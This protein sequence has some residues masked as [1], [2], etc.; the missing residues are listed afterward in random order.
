MSVNITITTLGRAA[1]VNAENTGTNPVVITQVG[2]T[3]TAVT[4]TVGTTSL[5]GELKRISGVAGDVVADDTI[6]INLTDDSGDAYSMRSFALYLADGTLFAIYGQAAP[7][8][9][10]TAE[11]IAAIAIDTIF[12]DIDAALL[13]FGTAEFT[14]PPATTDRAGVVELATVA[15]A[16]AG[17]DAL[18]ALTPATAKAAI[19]GWLLSQDGSGSGLDA[20]LL[21]GQDGSYY[22]NIAARLG[23]TPVN[24]A[25]DLMTGLL[26]LSGAPT[27]TD[28]ATT[29]AYVDALVTASAL[30]TKL[31]TVDGSGSGLDSDLLDGQD[32]AYYANIAARLG[33][34]PVNKA[35]D[36]M[37]G[38]LRRSGAPP[39]TDH[40]TTKAY[41]DAL[42][43]AAAIKTALLTV[44][45]S[46]SGIDADLLDGLDAAVFAR[47]AG[48]TLTGFLSLHADPTAAMHAATRQWVL[49]QIATGAIGFTPVNRAGDTMTGLLRLSAAPTLADHA[50]TK[51]YVDALVTAAAIKTALLTVDGSGSGIDADLLDGQDGAYYADIASRLGFSPVNKAGDTMLGL[52]TLSGAPT[53]ANHAATKIYVD[54]LVAASALLTKI[55]TVDGAGSGLDAD[56]LDGQDGAFY[57]NIA[58]RLGFTPVN[59]A[60]DTMGGLLTLSGNPSNNLHAAPKQ[61]VDALTAASALLSALITVDGSGCG[62]DADLLDG[63]HASAFVLASD[64]TKFGSNADGYWKKEENGFIEQW[65]TVTGTFTQGSYSHNWPIPFTDPASV[66][67]QVTPYNPSGGT[68]SGYDWWAQVQAVAANN[69][70]MVVQDSG[71]ALGNGYSWRAIGQ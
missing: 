2:I 26:R 14:N 49:A 5:T 7:L 25:G 55:L 17:I 27:L 20:D 42:V 61:Y 59:K 19:L 62:L 51:A 45:G 12:A 18:R 24:K 68:S 57:V 65:G 66:C 63:K 21:D 37:G 32:G 34:T 50:T 71:S 58:A 23:F 56:L 38:L 3:E 52:L 13:T 15:E 41:V 39:L 16:Q 70:T 36:L 35:G 1:L 30:L 46:G 47:V 67:L 31:L 6:H 44:D 33:F 28:H 4:P 64:V 11:S 9:V 8:I 48:G 29:K 40:A 60:G 53:A 22:A 43:T 10:K 69:F 54:G